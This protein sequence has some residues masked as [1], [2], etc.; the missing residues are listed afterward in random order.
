MLREVCRH[1]KEVIYGSEEE[2]MLGEDGEEQTNGQNGTIRKGGLPQGAKVAIV[3]FDK[4]VHFY[5][6][7]VC[8]GSG[9]TGC[10]LTCDDR[11]D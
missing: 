6:L 11:P 1:L 4:V 3:T 2:N 8:D 10:V 7:K 5:N 9:Q